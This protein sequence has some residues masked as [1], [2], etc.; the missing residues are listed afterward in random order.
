MATTLGLARAGQLTADVANTVVQVLATVPGIDPSVLDA[1]TAT[2]APTA[3]AHTP[4][5]SQGKEKKGK[6]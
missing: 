4:A 5:P 6:N 1:L 3:D 2:F